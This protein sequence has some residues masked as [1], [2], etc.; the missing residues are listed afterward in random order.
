MTRVTPCGGCDLTF[1]VWFSKRSCTLC[2]GGDLCVEMYGLVDGPCLSPCAA[3]GGCFEGGGVQSIWW[4][5]THRGE[6][7]TGVGGAGGPLLCCAVLRQPSL[8][9]SKR[10]W[11]TTTCRAPSLLAP[12]N[13]CCFHTSQTGAQSHS[14]PFPPL[15]HTLC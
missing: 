15:S 13:W 2:Q 5:T 3:A 12:L 7:A 9:C 4:T 14:L 8:S 1:N 10:C 11:N 6:D